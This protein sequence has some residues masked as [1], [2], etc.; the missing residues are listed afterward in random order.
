MYG[1]GNEN[2][3]VCYLFSEIKFLGFWVIIHSD[4]YQ[5]PIFTLELI[6]GLHVD[7]VTIGCEFWKIKIP[8]TLIFHFWQ[9]TPQW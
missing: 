8:P 5:T 3:A 2:M 6:K 9:T 4:Q 7:F 1:L